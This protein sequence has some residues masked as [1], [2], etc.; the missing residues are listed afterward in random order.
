MS[1]LR[2]NA[3]NERPVPHDAPSVPA[4]LL[5]ARHLEHPGPVIVMVHGY[6][7]RPGHAGNCPHDLIYALNPVSRSVP[8]WPRGLGFGA[9]DEGEGIAMAFGWN[10]RGTPRQAFERARAAGTILAGLVETIRTIDPAR[11]VHVIAHSLGSEVVFSA[12]RAATGP[13]FDRIILLAAASRAARA[14]AAMTCVAGRQ[15]ELINVTSRENTL[16]DLIAERTMPSDC[17]T[18][19]LGAGLR[20][21]NAVTLQLDCPRTLARLATLGFPVA[22]PDRRVCHWS[23]YTRAGVMPLYDQL[24]RRPERVAL[25]RIAT[26]PRVHTAPRW[27]R[28]FDHIRPRPVLPAVA[29][30]S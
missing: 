10:A 22:P 29:K 2:I 4:D 15:A 21:D 8:S 5:L 18:A 16:F 6:S 26:D 28:I 25:A 7:Y 19:V 30:P 14:K 3:Q 13:V 20:L 1:I 24:L 9:G 11:K 12:L 17:G 23:V 27:S